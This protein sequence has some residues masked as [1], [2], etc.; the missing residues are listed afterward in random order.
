MLVSKINDSCNIQLLGESVSLAKGE[1]TYIET[2]FSI[3]DEIEVTFR[4]YDAVY[5]SSTG[6]IESMRVKLQS[7]DH[8]VVHPT[9]SATTTYAFKSMFKA[10]ESA[11]ERLMDLI[12][13]AAAR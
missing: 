7:V 4:V 12:S 2:T 11:K 9:D 10:P 5:S 6:K 8:F 3:D 13:R 1:P